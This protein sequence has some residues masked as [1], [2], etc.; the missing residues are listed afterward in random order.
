VRSPQTG[1]TIDLPPTAVATIQVRQLFGESETNEG[2]VAEIV[3][4]SLTGTRID[5]LFVA[6]QQGAR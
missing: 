1:F 3:S 5:G 4:G 2:A 6:E